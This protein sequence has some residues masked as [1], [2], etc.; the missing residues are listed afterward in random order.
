MSER[1]TPWTEQE[2]LAA[3]RS[4]EILD[5]PPEEGFD[6]L[7]RLAAE[8]LGTPIAAVTLVDATRQWFKSERGFGVRETPLDRSVC[9]QAMNEP[10]GLVVPDL[11]H[12]PRFADNPLVTGSPRLRFYAGERL[13]TREGLPLGMLCVLDTAPRPEGITASQAWVLRA[14]AEQVTA[15][16]ELRRALIAQHRASARH[17]QIIDSTTNHAIIAIDGE[18]QVTRFNAGAERITGWSEAEMLGQSIGRL[19]TPEDLADGRMELEIRR[20][21]EEGRSPDTRFHQRKGGERFW[22][23]GEMRPLLDEAGR[24]TGLVKVFSDRTVER[25]AERRLSLLAEASAE[26]LGANDPDA[27]LGPLLA[28]GAELL[29]FDRAW[30]CRVDPDGRMRTGFSLGDAEIDGAMAARVAETRRPVVLSD[31]LAFAGFPIIA[32]EVLHGVLS[33][34]STVR[35]TFDGEAL[36]FFATLARFIAVVRERLDRETSLRELNA[37]LE[38]RVAERTRERDRVWQVSR[39]MLGVADTRGV[40]RSVNP[41]WAR[42]LG[43]PAGRLGGGTSEWIEHPDERETLSAAMAGL[44]GG[45]TLTLES[46]FRAS[47]GAWRVLSWTAVSVEGQT[48]AVA[49][50]MTEERAR[51]QAL[52]SSENFTRLALSA[53]GG[54]GV[55]TFDMAADRYR[56]DA[57]VAE[58]Y[59]LDP[60]AAAAGGGRGP[61]FGRGVAAGVAPEQFFASVHPDDL[62]QARRTAER[63]TL[64]SEP[65]V[66]FRV[67]AEGRV[68]WIMSRCHTERDA[69]GA[70]VGRTGV[71]IEITRLRTLEDQLRQAQK[72]EAVGQ[73]TGGLAHDFNNLLT[74]IV[75]SLEL[76]QT[77]VAQGGGKVGV[78]DA[79]AAGVL[80][81]ADAEPAAGRSGASGRRNGGSDPPDGWAGDYRRDGGDRSRQHFGRQ[82]PARECGAQ[83]LHQ[84][85]RCDGVGRTAHGGDRRA[86]ARREGRS[87]A[88]A[89]ARTLRVAQRDGRGGGHGARRS[90]A[91]VRP[92]LHHQADRRRNRAWIVDDLW[93]RAPV[94]RAGADPFRSGTR[95][96]GAHAAAAPCG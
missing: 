78:S 10:G 14:L 55:W 30:I 26:L 46:R 23:D 42:I 5:T 3:L 66:E 70:P 65:D 20:A 76:L 4:Y 69:D 59:G 53:V 44:P 15:R 2:R 81:P 68:R 21:R 37:T 83:S 61:V 73:L 88:G 40:W 91:G 25:A 94:G 79:S 62:A 22:A 50:D 9:L 64:A 24:V 16:L 71:G 32:G 75:G 27:V 90:G 39:D 93:F 57:A 43:W 67:R 11:A 31:D 95:H 56:G 18:G 52:R 87:R 49:R 28:R 72:M 86:L 41:A 47:D 13:A 74:G 34:A 35:R 17:R 60:A 63:G 80:A 36:S 84:C 45:A 51:D 92:V 58:L 12:D 33:F 96:D 54:V 85:A 8:L 82:Q 19:F 38:Q 77:R 1:H 7:T 48:Y 29:G 89:A 6:A